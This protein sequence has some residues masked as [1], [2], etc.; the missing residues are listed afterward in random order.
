MKNFR[1]RFMALCGLAV[2]AAAM[3]APMAAEAGC[4]AITVSCPNG[5][6]STCTGTQEGNR[7]IYSADCLNGGKCSST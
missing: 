3:L 4:P 6:I 7:C 1:S 5:G 2:L